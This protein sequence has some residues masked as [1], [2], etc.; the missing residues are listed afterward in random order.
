MVELQT[1]SKD[2]SLKSPMRTPYPVMHLNSDSFPSF[3]I[4]TDISNIMVYCKTLKLSM[5]FPPQCQGRGN[6]YS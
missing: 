5:P 2:E 1:V 6:V 4:Q 3:L